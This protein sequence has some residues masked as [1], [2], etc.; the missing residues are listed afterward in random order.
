MRQVGNVLRKD[1]LIRYEPRK[2]VLEQK[3]GKCLLKRHDGPCFPELSFRDEDA[4]SKGEQGN[5]HRPL[6]R[7]K[8]PNIPVFAEVFMDTLF[9]CHALDCKV[10]FFQHPGFLEVPCPCRFRY[11]SFQVLED[12]LILSG[13]EIHHFSDNCPINGL[14]HLTRTWSDAFT[15]LEEHTGP[16]PFLENGIPAP[17]DGI[18]S[19]QHV[20][21]IPHGPGVGVGSEIQRTVVFNLSCDIKTG[22]GMLKAQLQRDVGFVVFEVYVVFGRMFLYQ[23]VLQKEGFFL[24]L[25]EYNLHAVNL[26]DETRGLR[27]FAP[28]REVRSDAVPYAL[29]FTDIDDLIISIPEDVDA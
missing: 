27:I 29:C 23:V 1:D 8:S 22:E 11:A 28:F 19:L 15:D 9:L 2:I 18:E 21:N 4:L 10:S 7:R 16:L 17:S 26:P 6:S 5:A 13:E 24:A 14:V 20:E 25:G 12:L 3:R